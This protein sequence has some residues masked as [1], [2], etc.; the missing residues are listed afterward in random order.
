MNW[1]QLLIIPPIL[2]GIAFFYWMNLEDR[3][4]EEATPR[5]EALAVRVT[6]VAETPFRPSV[7]GYGRVAAASTWSAISQ[8]QGRAVEVNPELSPGWIVDEGDLLVAIDPRDY[9]IALAKA[10]TAR[11]SARA[12]LRELDATA[13]NTRE[14][15]KLER[16]IEAFLQTEFERQS[17]LLERGNVAQS[18]VDQATRTLLSQ[19]KVVLEL[20][21]RLNL[22]PVQREIHE[23]SLATRNAEIEEAG[24]NL[25][26]TRIVAPLTGRISRKSVSQGQFV[27][28]GDNLLTVESIDTAEI[29]AEFR[30]QTLNN[31]FRL[32]FGDDL[33]YL[34][35]GEDMK[36]AF[37][38]VAGLDLVVTVHSTI[39]DSLV[40]PAKLARFSGRADE[41]TGAVGIVVE[42]DD[43]GF[44][45]P[46]TRRPPLINGSFVEVRLSAPEPAS[47]IRIERNALRTDPDGVDFVFLADEDSRL[48]RRD[49]VV[50]P[51]AGDQVVV[52]A[53]LAEGDR[54][55]LSDPQPAVYGMLLAPVTN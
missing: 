28:T 29:L 6:E 51:V 53:G 9:E 47:S 31:F 41:Q 5:E 17:N 7:T 21:N 2:V 43:P 24:R 8:V 39:K 23:T 48:A 45:D 14:T 12:S 35:V 19:Q 26:R 22:M 32:L 36:E 1:R 33:P 34:V 40:W 54:V 20:E 37:E 49:V 25:Q 30:P 11:D 50:G 4:G 46:V 38:I 52:L 13:A 44:P 15:L 16:R 10:E 27:R 18:V 42:V 55:V 3:R